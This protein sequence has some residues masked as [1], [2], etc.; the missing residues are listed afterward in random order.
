MSTCSRVAA[1]W[2]AAGIEAFD[3]RHVR[4]VDVEPVEG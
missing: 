1:R 3:P 4:V 2:L